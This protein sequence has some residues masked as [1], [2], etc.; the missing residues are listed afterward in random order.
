MC[1]P[2]S[3]GLEER[4]MGRVYTLATLLNLFFDLQ[5]A[6]VWYNR[7]GRQYRREQLREV[8]SWNTLIKLMPR[9]AW[10]RR[11]RGRYFRNNMLKWLFF[12][13]T[14][15]DKVGKFVD[16]QRDQTMLT[17]SFGKFCS[18]NCTPSCC[19]SSVPFP[20]LP[21][22]SL[23]KC[24]Y[25]TSHRMLFWFSQCRCRRTQSK[26]KAMISTRLGAL[27]WNMFAVYFKSA[28]GHFH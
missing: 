27:I 9:I 20:L 28:N 22:Y 8:A 10:K 14:G 16:E 1:L 3:C 2:L 23:W 21:H 17:W 18:P 15:M 7:P 26:L 13:F 12:S 5:V 6:M 24:Q 11:V 19:F 4:A 25:H